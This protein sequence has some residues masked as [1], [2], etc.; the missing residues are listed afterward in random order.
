MIKDENIYRVRTSI[1]LSVC[2][3]LLLISNAVPGQEKV[4]KYGVYELTLKGSDAGNP[5]IGLR[6][7]ATFTHGAETFTP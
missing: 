5:F 3:L 2:L 4:E 6:F 7:T 1:H